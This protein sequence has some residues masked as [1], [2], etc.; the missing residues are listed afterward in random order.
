M[1][2]KEQKNP[3]KKVI[4]FQKLKELLSKFTR[5]RV[6]RVIIGVIAFV[7]LIV[8][9]KTDFFVTVVPGHKGV[10]F[11]RFGGGLSSQVLDE[12]THFVL[13]QL[14]SVYLACT[15]RQSAYIERITADSK[16]F[17][18]VALWLNVEFQI[19]S[20]S[21]PEFFQ[22]YGIKS[23]REV[24]DEFITPNTNEVVKNI[25]IE[26]R[27]GD[28]LISQPVLKKEITLRLAKI[29]DEY[30]IDVID[31]DID[32]IRLA[33]QFRE[34]IAAIEF[35]SYE[36]QR[37]DLRLDVARKAAERR[38]LEAETLKQEMILQAEAKAEYNSILNRQ[39]ITEA[40]LE[41]K[42]LENSRSAIEKWNGSFPSN[43]GDVNKWPF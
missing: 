16:E 8:I 22:L 32:N 37:E 20:E 33:P 5:V 23:S 42:R 38:L 40:M 6:S 4:F 7:I 14:Q 11:K 27:I 10:L 2:E 31:V 28:I 41:Y 39:L 35:A 36:R 21:L 29:M 30:Y 25:I 17:Q 1:N 18:D 12:G 9:L 34:T 26:Y 19:R 15:S 43:L 24:I 3:N 13:P